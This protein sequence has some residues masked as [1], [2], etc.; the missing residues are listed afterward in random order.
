M[1]LLRCA[2]IS[3]GSTAAVVK[4][5]RITV[6]RPECVVGPEDLF[7]CKSQNTST[8]PAPNIDRER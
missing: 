2:S 5:D 1:G 7:V 4:L 6:R 8:D 3:D